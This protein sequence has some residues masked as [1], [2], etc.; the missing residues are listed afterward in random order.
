MTRPFHLTSARLALASLSPARGV[1]GAG[2]RDPGTRTRRAMLE[3]RRRRR[4]H[5]RAERAAVWDRWHA[6]APIHQPL[7]LRPTRASFPLRV[8][9]GGLTWIGQIPTRLFR[10]RL[11]VDCNERVI[12]IPFVLQRIGPVAGLRVL[13]FGCTDSVLSMYLATL[14]AAVVGVDLRDYEFEHPNF[15]F[16]RGDFL[17]QHLASGSFDAVVAVSAVEH[18]GMDVYGSETYASG[19]RRVVEEFRRLLKPG[20]RLL[21]TVPF[22]R[23]RTLRRYRIYDPPGLRELLAGFETVESEFYRKSPPGP[24]WVRVAEADCADA[25]HDRIAGPEGVALI[26]ARKAAEGRPAA[27]TLPTPGS[28]GA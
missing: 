1:T 13:D 25:G 21:L 19:D 26:V 2:R 27:P 6:A 28:P 12:E 11:S 18:C 9:L 8:L 23:R 3:I 10:S 4:S 14:G 24:Y 20:G 16:H 17:E 7:V 15:S 5:A 22:G